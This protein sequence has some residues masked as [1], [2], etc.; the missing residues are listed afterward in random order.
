MIAYVIIV[1]SE[2][3]F[4]Q[5]AIAGRVSRKSPN[6]KICRLLPIL[7]W[8]K[9]PTPAGGPGRRLIPAARPGSNK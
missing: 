9:K 6:S 4:P 5:Q 3:I 2:L 8:C 1:I 7:P